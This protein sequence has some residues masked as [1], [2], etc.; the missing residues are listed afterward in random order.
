MTFTMEDSWVHPR[1]LLYCPGLPPPGMGP[2]R[3]ADSS[4]PSSGGMRQA[5]RIMEGSTK[6]H[7]AFQ[8]TQAWRRHRP[9]SRWAVLELSPLPEMGGSSPLFQA[10]GG[11]DFPNITAQVTKT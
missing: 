4:S 1:A 8:A 10:L 9:A 5:D 3:R 11:S 2:S 7:R 6:C